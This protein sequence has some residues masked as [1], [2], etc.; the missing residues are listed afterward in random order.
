MEDCGQG[1]KSEC[2]QEVALSLSCSGRCR[3][4]DN[5]HSA[6]IQDRSSIQMTDHHKPPFCHKLTHSPPSLP[7][8]LYLLRLQQLAYTALPLVML[9][10]TSDYWNCQRQ[11]KWLSHSMVIEILGKTLCKKQQRSVDSSS[12]VA[13]RQ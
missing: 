9:A 8:S 12:D 11:L 3:E 13:Q 1:K 6:P 4:P 7:L 2:C 10:A 5:V